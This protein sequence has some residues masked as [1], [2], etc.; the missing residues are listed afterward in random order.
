[1]SR[2]GK[3]RVLDLSRLFNISA[4]TIRNDL[5]EMERAGLVDRVHG[6]AVSTNKSYYAMTDKERMVT[7]EREKRQ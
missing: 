2:E 1:M 5:A 4:V 6:G 3:V 7:N